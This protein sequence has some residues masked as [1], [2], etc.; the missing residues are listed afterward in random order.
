MAT[1]TLKNDARVGAIGRT[2]SGKTFLMEKLLHPQPRVCVIDNKHRVNWRGYALTD[3][4]TA[5]QLGDKMIYRPPE[6]A[7]PP[8]WFWT[9][10]MEE[11]NKRGGG[12][13]YIDEAAEVTTQNFCPKGLR[14]VVRLGRE[15]GVGVWWAAQEATAVNNVLIRQSD[16]L[17]MFMNHGASDRDKLIATAGDIGEVPA[18]L[19]FHEF[20][21]YEA[22]GEAYDS[23]N[24]PVYKYTASHQ[25]PSQAEQA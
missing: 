18:D 13:I 10:I 24:I 21:V 25:E 3:D 19:G 6:G 17:I 9:A 5:A 22:S 12:I 7:A 8:E 15:I 16:I 11:Y 14:T 1:F 20:V 23:S 2:G 4:P